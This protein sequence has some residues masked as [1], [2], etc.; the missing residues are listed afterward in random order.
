MADFFVIL[1]L[2]MFAFTV[3]L[4]ISVRVDYKEMSKRQEKL[5]EAWSDYYAETRK[6]LEL[7]SVKIK[8]KNGAEK[9]VKGVKSYEIIDSKGLVIFYDKYDATSEIINYDEVFE[10]SFIRGNKFVDGER[11]I[12]D[13]Y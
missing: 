5:Y 10:I 6:Y 4:A 9:E 13:D 2:V 7:D 8:Y 3:A 12:L 11:N 1:V